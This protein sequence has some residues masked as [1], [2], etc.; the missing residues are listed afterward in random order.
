MVCKCSGCSQMFDWIAAVWM[1][2]ESLRMR[3]L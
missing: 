1:A 2:A 3:V